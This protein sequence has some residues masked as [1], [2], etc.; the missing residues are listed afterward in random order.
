MRWSSDRKVSDLCVVSH[1]KRAN[2]HGYSILL[3]TEM[4]CIL[5]I[6]SVQWLLKSWRADSIPWRL[7]ACVRQY[8]TVPMPV[9]SS[10]L[11]SLN[12]SHR[13][14]M[15]LRNDQ[16]LCVVG[17]F[18]PSPPEC[19]RAPWEAV[20]RP[21]AIEQP[22]Y[23]GTTWKGHVQSMNTHV[24]QIHGRAAIESHHLVLC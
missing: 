9:A 2:S 5:D 21:D 19:H 22:L 1:P 7:P 20:V 3:G 18:L 8:H 10:I 12:P 11:Q 15:E 14:P 6:L 23:D 16:G 4:I 17:P 13:E 24:E